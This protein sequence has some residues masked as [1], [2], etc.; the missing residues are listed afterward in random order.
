MVKVPLDHV[1][2]I[3]VFILLLALITTAYF[4]NKF[5][6]VKHFNYYNYTQCS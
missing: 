3:R 5:D 4:N 1:H 6:E 2:G